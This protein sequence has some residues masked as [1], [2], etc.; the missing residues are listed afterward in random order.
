MK[1]LNLKDKP[2]VLFFVLVL[3]LAAIAQTPNYFDGTL[4]PR[5]DNTHSLGTTALSWKDIHVD[6]TAYLD[7]ADIG[8]GTA[9][10]MT[11]NTALV[12]NGASTGI[13]MLAFALT[14]PTVSAATWAQFK[15]HR[16]IK[17]VR[18]DLY[19]P[20][21][22][23]GGTLGITLTDG[24]TACNNSITATNTTTAFNADYTTGAT[25]RLSS[26]IGGAATAG[27]N[28]QVVIHIQDN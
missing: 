9:T 22:V 20:H 24:T 13:N 8:T 7:A 12:L 15:A 27:E 23:S 16:D 21:S 6:G 10:T 25:L 11:V 2:L 4:V 5:A 17:V 14:D 1:R 3:A 18:M 26:H 19:T 28:M